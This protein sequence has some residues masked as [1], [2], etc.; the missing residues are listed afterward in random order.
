HGGRRAVSERRGAPTG[1]AS[2]SGPDA[3]GRPI[4]GSAIRRHPPGAP[5]ATAPARR[6]DPVRSAPDWAIAPEPPRVMAHHEGEP[7]APFGPRRRREARTATPG[8]AAR[9]CAGLTLP[10][11]GLARPAPDPGRRGPSWVP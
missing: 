7:S 8:V 10:G 9:R 1:S 4:P 11:F 6:R 3:G 2:R 5:A